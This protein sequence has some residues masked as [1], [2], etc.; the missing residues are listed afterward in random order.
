M[1]NKKSEKSLKL[2]KTKVLKFHQMETLLG[3]LVDTTCTE[4]TNDAPKRDLRSPLG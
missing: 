3:G 4:E 1:K 2:K